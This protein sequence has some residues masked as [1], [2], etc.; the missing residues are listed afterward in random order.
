MIWLC[1]GS[2]ACRHERGVKE[3]H[4]LASVFAMRWRKRTAGNI[5]KVRS[6][7]TSHLN[8][9]VLNEIMPNAFLSTIV[10][11]RATSML[12][13]SYLLLTQ[14]SAP[15][16]AVSCPPPATL[17]RRRHGRQIRSAAH[18]ISCRAIRDQL[19]AGTHRPRTQRL[20]S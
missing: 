10:C 8:D 12:R 20:E 3:D 7:I 4:K 19:A 11:N 18:Y 17:S 14:A 13:V 6:V 16:T 1:R 2:C 9:I 5:R 15:G